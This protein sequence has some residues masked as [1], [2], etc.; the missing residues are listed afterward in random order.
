[1]NHI[2]IILFAF[3]AGLLSL[4][5]AGHAL[6]HKRDS[7]SALGWMSIS[8]T[9]PLLG[10]FLYWCLGVNRI[11]RRARQW[12]ESGRRLSGSEINPFAEPDDET[13]H[14]PQPATHLNDLRVLGD[15]VARTR[16]R[17]GNRITPLVN[18]EEAYPAMLAAIGRA[19][20]SIN[21]S[22]Y[23]FDA[24][25]IG[26]EFISALQNA[27]RRGVEVRV[28]IDAL[29]EKYSRRSPRTALAGTEVHLVRYLPLRHGAYINLRN[30]RKLL[31]IDGREAFT[32]GMNIRSRHQ[33]SSVDMATAIHDLHFSVQGP[34]VADL[35][36]TFLEDWY[37]VTGERLDAPSFFPS[38]ESW[39]NALARSISDGP[40]KEFRKLEHII[41]GALSCAKKSVRIMTPYF[42]P[43]RPMIAAL[44]TTALRGVDVRIVLPGLN[45]LPFVHW[46][47]RGLL[48][49]LLAN[50]I[51]VFYQ[52]PP[53]VHTKLF[54]VDDV[55]SLLGSANL[56]PR[57]LRL[58]FELNLSVFDEDF[59]AGLNRHFEQAFATSCE[60]T[61][62]ELDGRPLPV[63]LRDNCARLFSPY[64]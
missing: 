27:A 13:V 29:G 45:N 7:R 15:R 44:I 40:D 52:P 28:I 63:R 50:G 16:L 14:L 62:E 57:S 49:E 18:G 20:D 31:I 17:E 6:L 39:G 30:H 22:S 8:L 61:Q 26:A 2:F 23:I 33:P 59:A 51:R 24:D 19:E 32:G 36:S 10:P 9:L 56:D 25:G 46:A 58:N 42:V 54:L 64:L 3:C 1:M 11:S 12:Q 48:W 4:A 60:V 43:D 5:T 53:F 37:F 55:W 41:M 21:L 34:V 47:T 38:L 35:Q